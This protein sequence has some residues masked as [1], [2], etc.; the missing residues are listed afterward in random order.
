MVELFDWGPAAAGQLQAVHR[1]RA[2]LR[3]PRAA[4]RPVTELSGPC[5][6]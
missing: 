2:S 1:A 5:A 6:W 4:R 3:I